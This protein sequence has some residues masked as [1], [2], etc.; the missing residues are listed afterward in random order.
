M[1]RGIGYL[2]LKLAEKKIRVDLRYCYYEM[3]NHFQDLG[4]FD[5]PRFHKVAEVVGWAPK[6]VDSLA[7]RLIFRTFRNDDYNIMP[8][9]NENN[10]DIFFSAAV[11]SALIGSCSFVYIRTDENGQIRLEV[12]DGANATGIIDPSTMLLREGYAVLERNDRGEPTMEAYF[13]PG[14]VEIYKNDGTVE[15]ME[16]AV[17]FPLLVPVVNRPDPKRWFGHSRISRANMSIIDAAMR[18]LLRSEITAE[19]YSFPQKW[20][21]G[22]SENRDELDKWKMSVSAL[23]TFDKDQDGDHPVIG[24]FSQ[25][26]AGPHIEQIKMLAALFAGENGLTME[27]LGFSG[28][29]PTG[30]ESIKA[31]H[32]TLRLQARKAQKDFGSAF[33]N[34]GFLAV[35]LKDGFQYSRAAFYETTPVWRPIFEPDA[36][37]LSSIGDGVYKLSQAFPDAIDEFFLQDYLGI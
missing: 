26:S 9:F 30:A 17:E 1:L 33:L 19:F 11:L 5:D 37:M 28:A 31:A 32:E 15:I 8:I 10:P 3:K 22:L 36:A 23:L 4:I 34:V 14:R 29:N 24:Q 25:A 12:I 35:C 18:S 6:A 20:V 16:N 2:R 21:S 7:D 13:A 27:D